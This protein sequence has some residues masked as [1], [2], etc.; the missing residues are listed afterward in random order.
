VVLERVGL[1]GAHVDTGLLNRL[2]QGDVEDGPPDAPV[3]YT[4]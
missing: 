1:T 3:R 4:R 2:D